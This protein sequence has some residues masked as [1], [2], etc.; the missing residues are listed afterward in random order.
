MAETLIRF[1]NRL[2]DINSAIPLR[3]AKQ[4]RYT[5]ITVYS[6]IIEII[7]MLELFLG[8]SIGD[9]LDWP[10]TVWSPG[11]NV[12]SFKRQVD[13]QACNARVAKPQKVA[14]KR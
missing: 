8:M 11:V 14:G 13:G 9:D 3:I 12:L 6:T 2:R 5:G 10:P 4:V 1:P 7:A